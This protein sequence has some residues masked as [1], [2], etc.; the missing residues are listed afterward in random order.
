MFKY[1]IAFILL[2]AIAY[3]FFFED[4]QEAAGH[5]YNFVYTQATKGG[6]L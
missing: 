5:L 6:E 4:M 3:G 2:A 1:L